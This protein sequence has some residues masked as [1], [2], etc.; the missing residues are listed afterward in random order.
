[1]G[2]RTWRRYE[3]SQR[4]VRTALVAACALAYLVVWAGTAEA[5]TPRQLLHRY[6][7]VTVL[8][9]LEQFAP[10]QVN[11]F[12]NDSVLE[13]QTAPGVWSVARSNPTLATLPTQ[14]AQSCMNAGLGGDCYRLNQAACS[15]ADGTAGVACYSNA[16]QAGGPRKVEI[17]REDRK[18]ATNAER[19]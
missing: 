2:A 15:P 7:P 9:P 14:P 11:G 10:T 18:P 17:E 12:V 3:M 1:M 19:Q 6:Q 16:E 8:D 5:A 13:I 4:W